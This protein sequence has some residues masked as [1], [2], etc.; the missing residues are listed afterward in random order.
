MLRFY[1]SILKNQ[2]NLFF[3]RYLRSAFANFIACNVP[4]CI[5]SYGDR[6]IARG[7]LRATDGADGCFRSGTVWTIIV[8]AFCDRL[9]FA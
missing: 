8:V 4:D 3:R 9:E 5:N 2:Y 1:L 6:L 7:N